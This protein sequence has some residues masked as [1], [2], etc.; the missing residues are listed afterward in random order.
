MATNPSNIFDTAG[1]RL[2]EDACV[3]IVRTAWNAEIVDKLEEGAARVLASHQ[4]RVETVTVPGA[5]E[6]GF[7]IQHHYRSVAHKPDAYIALGCVL[8]GGTPHFEFVSKAVTD[9]VNQL[10]LTLPVPT[11]FG[12]LTVDNK[13]QATERIGGSHGHKGEEA[14]VTAIHMI[15]WS[16]SLKV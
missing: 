8:R 5:V 15:H 11:I 16:S 13:Q 4:I 2:K 7:A 10:N 14:A 9:A 12:V 1:I 6:I 3:V